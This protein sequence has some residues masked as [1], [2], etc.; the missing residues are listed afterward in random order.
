MKD[1]VALGPPLNILANAS[2]DLNKY[3]NL[4]DIRSKT[5]RVSRIDNS[6]ENVEIR[7]L[8]L[9]IA[10]EKGFNCFAWE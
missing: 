8:L 2:V 10:K 4:N 1:E 3:E 9:Q 6:Y 5:K 7:N